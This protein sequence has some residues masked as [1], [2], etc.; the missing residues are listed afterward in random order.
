MRPYWEALLDILF[1][2]AAGTALA[3]CWLAGT[4]TGLVGTG[5]AAACGLVFIRAGTKPKRK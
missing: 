3:G 4:A 1:V 5:I 2:A